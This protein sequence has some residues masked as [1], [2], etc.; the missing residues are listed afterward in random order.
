MNKITVQLIFS[1]I[2]TQCYRFV[3]VHFPTKI[4]PYIFHIKPFIFK[5]SLEVIPYLIFTKL[6]A[7]NSEINIVSSYNF[8]IILFLLSLKN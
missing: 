1:F 5:H 8:Q 7:L 3:V 2:K 6:S 4:F